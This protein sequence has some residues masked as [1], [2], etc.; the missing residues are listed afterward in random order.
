MA[1]SSTKLKVNLSAP[2]AVEADDV[3]DNNSM[4]VEVEVK[5]RSQ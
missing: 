5:Q 3:A 4:T 2:V 1:F